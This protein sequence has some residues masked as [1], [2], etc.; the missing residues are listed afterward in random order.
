[1]E[2]YE[3]VHIQDDSPAFVR[4]HA[5]SPSAYSCLT[6]HNGILVFMVHVVG[7]QLAEGEAVLDEILEVLRCALGSEPAMT[8]VIVGH[9]EKMTVRRRGVLEPVLDPLAMLRWV[10]SISDGGATAA[11][12]KTV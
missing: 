6:A 12:S 11:P 7:D 4:I 8:D 9:L 10:A 3:P 1:M 5:N 2:P